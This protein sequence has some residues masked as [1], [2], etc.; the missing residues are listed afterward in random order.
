MNTGI[1]VS[2]NMLCKAGKRGIQLI[3]YSL[4]SLTAVVDVSRIPFTSLPFT[5]CSPLGSGAGKDRR[6]WLSMDYI[7]GRPCSMMQQYGVGGKWW[8]AVC[9]PAY[10]VQQWWVCLPNCM[11]GAM[12][13]R[14]LAD[15]KRWG[16]VQGYDP[17]WCNPCKLQPLAAKKLD[18]PSDL[19]SKVLSSNYHFGNTLKIRH[20][21]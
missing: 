2:I 5:A 9:P 17:Q 3:G 10:K 19:Q 12:V 13:L 20:Q 21:V 8:G 15:G 6:M 14:E 11:H 1:L 7:S 4:I 16:G 18:S